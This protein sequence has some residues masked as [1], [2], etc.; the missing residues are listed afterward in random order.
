MEEKLIYKGIIFDL[1]QKNV[2][3]K[4][5]M[6]KRD[7]IR[8]PGGVGVICIIDGKILL[9]RQER[10]A[11]GKETLEIPAGELDV[12]RLWAEVILKQQASYSK[13]K[14]YSAGFVGRRNSIKYRFTV[15]EIQD[16]FKEELIDVLYLPEAI[17]AAMGDVAIVAKFTS[18]SRRDEFFK[19]AL[20]RKDRL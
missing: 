11:I 3:I 19:V 10:P 5:K 7:I 14:R 1:V 18:P 6:Y 13:L 2:K 12:Y 4:D 9:V 20:K 15:K 8:H 16:M 17:A